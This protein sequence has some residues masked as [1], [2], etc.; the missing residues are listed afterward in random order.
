MEESGLKKI[1]EREDIR[2]IA[3]MAAEL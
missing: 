3:E 2:I 1:M